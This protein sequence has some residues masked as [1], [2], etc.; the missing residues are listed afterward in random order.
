M[1]DSAFVDT[2]VLVYAVDEDEAAK[3]DTARELLASSQPGALT[4]SPQILGEFYVTVTRKLARPIPE[5]AAAKLLE[6]LEMLP[7]VQIDAAL[8]KHGVEI[9][10]SAQVS[11]WDGLVVA[12][13]ARAD[14]DRLLSEDLNDGQ[15]IAGVLVENPFRLSCD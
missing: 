2:N 9:S 15:E 1:S 6:W 13:A 4:L 14:C 10:R 3:R 5:A 8:V 7:M 11:Y 12:A